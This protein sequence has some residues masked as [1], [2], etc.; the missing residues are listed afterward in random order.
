MERLNS[1][2]GRLERGEIGWCHRHA[3]GQRH[4]EYV[5][6]ASGAALTQPDDQNVEA[7]FQD[8]QRIR[9]D[10]IIRY[11]IAFGRRILTKR[12]AIR[13]RGGRNARP[14]DLDAVKPK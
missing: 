6:A 4:P 7:N 12:D 3:S 13:V 5:V 1:A 8:S 2:V 9:S 11:W 10:I 14:H